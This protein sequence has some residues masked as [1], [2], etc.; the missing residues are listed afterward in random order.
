MLIMSD[1]YG[2]SLLFYFTIPIG[3]LYIN[4]GEEGKSCGTYL[5]CGVRYEIMMYFRY[6]SYMGIFM[7][8][9]AYGYSQSMYIGS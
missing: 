9:L 5:Y 7:T 1:S 2:S 8:E 4:T 3:R 6:D